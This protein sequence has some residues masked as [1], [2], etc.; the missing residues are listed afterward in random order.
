AARRL[1][2]KPSLFLPFALVA[3]V[4]G[5][6]LL[7]LHLAPRP[8]FAAVLAPPI[9]AFYGEIYLHYPMDLVLL[10]RLF[11]YAQALTALLLSPLALAWTVRRAPERPPE[12]AGSPWRRYAS[13]FSVTLLGF[14]LAQ[15]AAAGLLALFRLIPDGAARRLPLAFWDL[16]LQGGA[17]AAGLAVEMVLVFAVPA[18]I[19]Q[20]A[21]FLRGLRASVATAWRNPLSTAAVV[22]PPAL[23]YLAAVLFRFG[24]PALMTRTAP[25]AALWVLGS[26]ILVSLAV[27]VF[28]ATG[29][30]LFYAGLLARPRA[31][32][33][34]PARPAYAPGL[35]AAAKTLPLVILLAGCGAEY[36]AE[37]MAWKAG[38]EKQ[39]LSAA[40]LAP[41]GVY[42]KARNAYEDII[43]RHPDSPQAAEAFLS[44]GE[45][46]A[47]QKDE[48]KAE[49]ILREA[50]ARYEKNHREVGARAVTALARMK[51]SAGR[52]DEA[53]ALYAEAMGYEGTVAGVQAAFWKARA[54]RTLGEF[55][56]AG[57]HYAESVDY[58]TR[59]E[60]EH[61]GSRVAM[62]ALEVRYQCHAD[63]QQWRDAMAALEALRLRYPDTFAARRAL[64]MKRDV[65]RNLRRAAPAAA[66]TS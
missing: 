1:A 35:A 12:G 54:S 52:W 30:S 55:G 8:P 64:A 14:V 60:K 26:G 11:F 24:L 42:V 49:Q 53:Q 50:A 57:R 10:P 41:A 56:E 34:A 21:G 32:A 40:P 45:L 20:N 36:S 5:A 16:G 66:V 46:Y 18:I 28:V 47:L 43:R 58:L 29:A 48:A 33:P 17:F 22:L 44:I 65:M 3:A 9:R 13:V 37:K 6:L 23:L 39:R 4:E 63:R 38:R 31:A 19:L 51:E 62:A 15:A 61:A 7:V 59:M 27:N 25:E 2:G